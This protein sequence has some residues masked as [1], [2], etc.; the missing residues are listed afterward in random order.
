MLKYCAVG[1]N[2]SQPRKEHKRETNKTVKRERRIKTNTFTL[3]MKFINRPIHETSIEQKIKRLK[4]T[5]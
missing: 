5:K 1:M 2:T 3:N 4:Y